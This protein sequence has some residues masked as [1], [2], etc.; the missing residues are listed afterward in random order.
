MLG[1]GHSVWT[2][3]LNAP[4]RCS[5]YFAAGLLVIWGSLETP[6]D[7]LGD[8]YLQS[9]HMVQHMLLVAVAPPL[10]LLGLTP[11]MASALLRLPGLAAVTGPIPGQSIYAAGILFWH[12]PFAYNLALTDGIAHIVEHLI[13]VAIGVAF[14]WPL[15]GATSAASRWRLTDGQ[16]LIYIFIGTFPMMAVALPLQFSRTVFYTSYATAPRLV[17]SVTPVIDQTIAGALMMAIDMAVLGLDGLIVLYRWFEKEEK[18]EEALSDQ[19]A[20]GQR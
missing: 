11:G 6:L 12:I 13:F 16:K 10:L 19:R 18:D 1:I 7:P 3:R 9:A 15:I 2:R 8:R 5:V 17:A 4:A 20:V 14:W